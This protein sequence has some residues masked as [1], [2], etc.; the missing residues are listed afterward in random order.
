MDPLGVIVVIIVVY[1]IVA[2]AAGEPAFHHRLS[3]T[4]ELVVSFQKT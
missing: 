4:F 1:V 2:N 3:L